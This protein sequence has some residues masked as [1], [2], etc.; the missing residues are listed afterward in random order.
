MDAARYALVKE[1]WK[2]AKGR[3][4]G[5]F[6]SCFPLFFHH[7]LSA[8][9]KRDTAGTLLPWFAVTGFGYLQFQTAQVAHINIPFFHVAAVCHI[10]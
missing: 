8:A 10:F 6:F 9:L 5:Q 3:F 2:W 4:T 1:G 7:L